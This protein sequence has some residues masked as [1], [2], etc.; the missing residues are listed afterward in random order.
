MLLCHLS[1]REMESSDS[2]VK[3]VWKFNTKLR[4]LQF[5]YEEEIRDGELFHPFKR[6]RSYSVIVHAIQLGTLDPQETVV[7]E[8]VNCLSSSQTVYSI[9]IPV[10]KLLFGPSEFELTFV[11]PLGRKSDIVIRFSN[12]SRRA[13]D[14][15]IVIKAI[16][17]TGIASSSYSF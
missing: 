10:S 15:S 6:L 14:Y 9:S 16:S 5:P 3:S 13:L 12:C 8:L 1:N 17:V 2:S 7:F 11:N 4:D